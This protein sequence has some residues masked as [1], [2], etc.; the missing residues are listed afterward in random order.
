[1]P[2]SDPGGTQRETVWI[3]MGTALGL[4]RKAGSKKAGRDGGGEG[5]LRIDGEAGAATL[6]SG[7]SH[8]S[9][10]RDPER[11][12]D[13]TVQLRF[14]DRELVG[15]HCIFLRRRDRTWRPFPISTCVCFRPVASS[16]ASFSGCDREKVRMASGDGCG[17]LAQAGGE[18]GMLA[19]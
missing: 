6:R 2:V 13:G 9:G 15:G 8:Y 19:W 10:E 11:F 14:F 5:V 18:E 3:W 16:G 12:D 7:G 4:A 1:M 17:D